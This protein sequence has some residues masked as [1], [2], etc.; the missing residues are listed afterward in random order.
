MICDDLIWKNGNCA[1]ISYDG[2]VSYCKS[3]TYSVLSLKDVTEFILGFFV[4][5]LDV[6]SHSHYDYLFVRIFFDCISNK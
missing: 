1:F 2:F 5:V 4:V 3:F 6:G